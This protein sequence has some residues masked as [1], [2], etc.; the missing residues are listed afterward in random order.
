MNAVSLPTCTRAARI[1]VSRPI[2]A[3]IMPSRS[4]A[5]VPAKLKATMRR[6]RRAT[7][8]VA[9]RSSRFELMRTT[10]ALSRATSVPLPMAIPTSARAR[11]GASLTPSPI[12]ATRRPCDRSASTTVIFSSGRSPAWTRSIPSCLATARAVGSRSPVTIETSSPI[13]RRAATAWRA[14]PRTASASSTVPA[15]APS[16]STWMGVTTPSPPSSAASGTSGTRAEPPAATARPPTRALMPN[17]GS[18]SKASGTATGRP[19]L[20]ACSTTASPSG[21]SE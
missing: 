21:C 10:S 12:M 6:A 1:G 9:T 14:E 18:Y 16:T 7:A 19:R 15:Y 3:S 8:T 4:T 5:T 20:R 11:A 2:P 13:A 17:P